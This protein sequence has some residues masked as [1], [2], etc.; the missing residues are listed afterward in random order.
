MDEEVNQKISQFIDNEMTVDEALGLLKDLR[1]QPGLQ[2]T[3][4]R[5]Q[6]ASN[7]L[8]GGQGQN[9]T[10]SPDFLAGVKKG[11]ANEPVYLFP[12]KARSR[13]SKQAVVAIAA[14]V[15]LVA[16]LAA[17][18]D[19]DKPAAMKLDTLSASAVPVAKKQ[20]VLAQKRMLAPGLHEE[21]LKKRE[22]SEQNNRFNDFLQAH[23]TSLYTNGAATFQPYVQTVSYRQD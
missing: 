3:V 5:Y 13:A 20:Q 1:S 17:R 15:A 16:V 11:I 6:V 21:S 18:L 14:S 19:N 8:S 22:E 10:A 4:N 12:P 9:V 2:K 7:A 23:N